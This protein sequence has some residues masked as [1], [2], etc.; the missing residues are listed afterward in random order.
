MIK[1]YCAA[2]LAFLFLLLPVKSA[3]G[4]GED[5]PEL[6]VGKIYFSG[7][8]AF[9]SGKLKSLLNIEESSIYRNYP[10]RIESLNSGI[11]NIR[12]HYK[13]QGFLGVDISQPELKIITKTQ[14]VILNIK[15]SEGI[16]TLINSI[17]VE[18]SGDTPGL[19]LS[20]LSEKDILEKLKL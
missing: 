7:N 17:T 11:E 14:M 1:K 15:I 13:E 8:R 2:A 4:A 10:F 5:K 3:S 20:G 16:K 6:Y 9:S 18:Y 19:R 12:N